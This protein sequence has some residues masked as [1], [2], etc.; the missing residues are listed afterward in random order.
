MISTQQLLDDFSHLI[1]Q[2]QGEHTVFARTAAYEN[3]SD[4]ALIFIQKAD[5][6]DALPAAIVTTS[7]V[8]SEISERFDGFVACVEDVRLSQAYIKQ[9]YDDYASEDAEWSR[10]HETAVVHESA[11]IPDSCRI[12]PNVVV[13]KDVVLG[14]RVIVRANSVIEFGA[15]IGAGSIINTCVTIGYHSVLGKNVIIKSGCAI[16]NEGFGFAQTKE[17]AYVRIPHTGNVLIEDDV[18]VGCNCCIDRG[19]Y[20]STIIR[21]GVKID[22]LCH[23]AHNVLLEEDCLLVAQ[24]GIAGSSKF[25]KRVIASGQTGVLD[26]KTVADDAILVHRTGVMEDIPTGGMWGG[27]PPKP[28]R[29]HMK[30]MKLDEVVERRFKKLEAKLL[31]LSEKQED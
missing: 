8:A 4:D 31:E 23:I 28:F 10:I 19:T 18:F 21:R 20:G 15:Q 14:D 1:L 2:S 6:L 17:K 11:T 24:T 5:Q 16:G 9:A 30:R 29:E 12:G 25:G 27:L 3:A 22:N 13:G 26:H 7:A